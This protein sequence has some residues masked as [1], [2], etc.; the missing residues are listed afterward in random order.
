MGI[1]RIS[2]DEEKKVYNLSVDDAN[3]LLRSLA[4]FQVQL[5]EE[6]EG[7]PKGL[8]IRRFHSAH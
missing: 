1:Y 7:L 3:A 8:I 5:D 2:C 6:D 4:E